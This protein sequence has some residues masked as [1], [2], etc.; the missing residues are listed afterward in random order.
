MRREYIS[1]TTDLPVEISFNDIRNYPIHWHD[2]I[3][4]IFVLEGTINVSIE[5]GN[6]I[7]EE[8]EIEIINCDEAH[9]IHSQVENRVIVFHMD[10]NFFE[11]YFNDIRN[12]FFYT[13]SSEDWAQEEEK[14]YILRKYL[15]IIAC[16]AIQ[17][18]EKYEDFIE[19][20]MVDLLYH[21]IN[22]F[23]QLIYDKDD[24]KVKDEQFERYDRIVRYI[25][26]NYKNKISLQ[27]IAKREFLSSDYLSHEIK[28]NFGYSFKD[29][30]NLTRVEE[31][32]KLL[33]ETDKTISEISEELGFSHTRY[34]NKHFKK[35]Y[36][37]TP[38]QY[39]KKYKVDDE[40]LE[41]LKIYTEYNIKESV[42]FISYF[43]E[44][45]DRFNYEDKIIK[46]NVD[47]AL[48]GEE[49][50][51]EFRDTI[52]LG[53]AKFILMETQRNFIKDIQKDIGFNYAIVHGMFSKE[54]EVVSDK[55]NDFFNWN[56]VKK[57]IEFLLSI[58]LKPYIIINEDID[59]DILLKLLDGFVDYFKEEFG[60]YEL[61]KWKV[62]INRSLS[63]EFEESI[64]KVI[65]DYF[66][67]STQ[68]SLISID[69]DPI[70]DTC[71]MLPYIIENSIHSNDLYFR[72]FDSNSLG[73]K[74]DNESF[75]G[76]YGL[77]NQQGIKKPS[78]YAY[79][80]LAR[81]GDTIIDKGE[82]YIITKKDEDIQI[83]LYSYSDEIH[84]LAMLEDISTRRG[85]KRTTERKYSLNLLNLYNDYKIIKYEINEKEGSAYN[86]WLKLDKPK[87]L[88]E[89]ELDL[90]KKISFPKISFN[91]AKKSAVFNIVSKVEG[92]G[93]VLILL[94]KVQ[95]HLY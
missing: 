11:K 95:K 93:A 63:K 19:D 10:P 77:L 48:D 32:V 54:M 85:I 75:F 47:T 55:Y 50:N 2:S 34:F 71:Y 39:R 82:G 81:L 78:Y 65:E 73:I 90:I 57:V 89:E 29:F 36:N 62:S 21:L 58:E 35:H 53:R 86:Y 61:G 56:Y 13:N 80:L 15:S 42:D 23:H 64:N 74:M 44:D 59:E 12:I 79:Y 51:H 31:S 94:Q 49:F 27:D 70:Y 1:Y 60:E 67:I 33:L 41:K 3:E 66:C 14:Y 68:S 72:A 25:Y 37:C 83:L 18:G 84:K 91:Y 4:I 26:T 40:T 17:K 69:N 5:S 6:Y 76:D 88:T 24:F 9:S 7:V 30:L 87:R 52:N 16:E 43:L 92:Y 22:N 8:G 38:M 45:Y 28:N 20:T 46:I